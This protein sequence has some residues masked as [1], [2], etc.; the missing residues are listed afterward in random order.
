MLSELSLLEVGFLRSESHEL[1]VNV[2]VTYSYVRCNE[3]FMNKALFIILS[4]ILLFHK[5]LQFQIL[6]RVCFNYL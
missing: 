1:I 4:I 2:I 5:L 3:T 6:H